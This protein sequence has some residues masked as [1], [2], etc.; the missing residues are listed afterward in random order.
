MANSQKDIPES[1][2]RSGE[3]Y[4]EENTTHG[5]SSE[6]NMHNELAYKGDE[7]DGKVCDRLDP[8][9]LCVSAL[10]AIED[11]PLTWN[12]SRGLRGHS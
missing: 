9:C 11:F 1:E 6:K 3:V 7:S 10:D 2:K 4:E 5:P 8:S 12:R